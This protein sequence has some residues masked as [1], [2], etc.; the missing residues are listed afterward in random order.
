MK[1]IVF[2]I[3]LVMLLAVGCGKSA[4]TEG[5]NSGVQDNGGSMP[6]E[7]AM[8]P[9]ADAERDGD[10]SKD[11]VSAERKI[12]QNAEVR[13]RVDDIAGSSE[14]IKN[15]TAEL[16]G[17]PSDMAVYTDGQNAN[18]SMVLR[19]PRT[20]YPQLLSFISTL[21]HVDYKREYTNDVTSQYVD[22][23][24]RV[25]VLRTEEDSLLAILAKAEKI[26]DILKVKAQITA[27]RQE[28]ES[29]QAQLQAM[30]SSVEYAT[31]SVDL[32]QPANSEAA[33]NLDNLNVFSR[34]YRAFISGLNALTGQLANLLVFFFAALPGLLLLAL[35]LFAV[36]R[37]RKRRGKINE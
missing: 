29:L 6:V 11:M 32:Y 24:A 18:A 23:D 3:G 10:F 21:G 12:I 30:Q 37:L 2:I 35:I 16:Q 8:A 28:R 36:L 1:K 31:V 15:K 17:Y 33:V 13:L 14:K 22:L 4:E 26:E 9:A 5:Q 27:T 20:G 7:E 19:V 25:K 34:S